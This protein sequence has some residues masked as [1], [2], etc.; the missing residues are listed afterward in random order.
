MRKS[1]PAWLLCLALVF[2]SI[3]HAQTA[4][5]ASDINAKIRAEEAQ[6]SEI[7][8]TMHFL[9]DVYG[10]RLTGS[11]NAKAAAVW[12]VGR[13]AHEGVGLCERAP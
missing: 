12:G 8:R 7:M 2:N 5:D 3:A 11:P 9:S 10:P 13:R 4:S 1:F 6:H